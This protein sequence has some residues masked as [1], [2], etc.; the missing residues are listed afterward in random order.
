MQRVG[1]DEREPVGDP[2]CELGDGAG[3]GCR[4]SR[5]H[6]HGGDVAGDRE[7]GEGEEPSPGPTSTTESSGPTPASRTMRLTVLASTTKFWPHCL[8][9]L[10]P[11]RAAIS[12]I[13]PAPR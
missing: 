4:E 13:C 11:R 6:L 8:V 12:R 9:G 5:V 1:L 2:R 7:Q 10:R 3:K